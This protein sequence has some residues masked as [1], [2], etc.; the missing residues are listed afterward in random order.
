MSL[1]DTRRYCP[2][3]GERIVGLGEALKHVE[4]CHGPKCTTCDGKGLVFQDTHSLCPTCNG[5][6]RVK[7]EVP[8][9]AWELV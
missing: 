7:R 5:H 9:R 8:L 6:C 3:C 4:H 1:M 2:D